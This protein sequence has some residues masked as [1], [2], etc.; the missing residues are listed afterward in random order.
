[1]EG[2]AGKEG[3]RRTV[4]VTG[5]NR[6]V[7]LEFSRQYHDAGWQVIATELEGARDLKALGEGA[8][9]VALDVSTPESV[10]ALAATLGKEPIDLL[11]NMKPEDS[12]EFWSYDGTNILW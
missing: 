1:V 6:G 9:V 3:G 4:L 11:I 5:A 7:G 12:G 2:T 10:A 8:R